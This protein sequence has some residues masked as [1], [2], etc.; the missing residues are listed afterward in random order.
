M[1]GGLF[2]EAAMIVWNDIKTIA[3]AMKR[4]ML[5]RPQWVIDRRAI[6]SGGGAILK[7]MDLINKSKK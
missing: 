2:K 5:P 4:G 1:R 7:G 3:Q 6:I